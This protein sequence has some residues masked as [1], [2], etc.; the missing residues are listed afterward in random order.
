M[1][2]ARININEIIMA[3]RKVLKIIMAKANMVKFQIVLNLL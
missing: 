3:E 2:L 1:N